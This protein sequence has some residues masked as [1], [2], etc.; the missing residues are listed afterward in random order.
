[1]HETF[2]Q[3]ISETVE[4]WL[5]N[6]VS[7][8]YTESFDGLRLHYHQAVHPEEKAAIVM[9]HGFC[10]FFGKYHETAWRFYNA[11]YSVFFLELRGHGKS[12]RSKLFDDQRVYVDSF[13]EYVEDIHCFVDQVAKKNSLSQKLFLYC[14]SMGGTAGA[15]FLE[16]YPDVFS[17]AVL[18]S[19]MLKVNYGGIPDPAIDALAVYTR[20]TDLSENFAPGQHEW[21][22]EDQFLSSSCMDRDRYEYQ[23]NQRNED[24]DY[25]TWGGT[26]AWA[27]AAKKGTDAAVANA[28]R[29]AVPVLVCQ[30]GNDGMV[31]NEGQNEF[32]A[33]SRM[34]WLNVYEGCEHELFNADRNSRE[35]YYRDLLNFWHIMTELTD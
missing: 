21:R 32:R 2:R 3:F 12:E 17:C 18:S 13:D 25:Q 1:M 4:P 5:E 27:A 31:D 8:G 23:F 35:K 10:E 29:I 34:V 24:P 19:P 11:G 22:G 28:S 7:D 6:C 20:I 26:W 14:H 30:S 15:M 16:T 33:N 9:V